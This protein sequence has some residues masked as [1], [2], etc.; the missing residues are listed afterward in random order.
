MERQ[1]LTSD[2]LELR[3]RTAITRTE[4]SRPVAQA[5]QDGVISGIRSVLDYGCGRGDDVVRLRALGH[6]AVGWD[7]VFAPDGPLEPADVVNLGYVINVIE[8]PVERGETL[9]RAWQLAKSALVVAARLD[10]QVQGPACGDGIRTSKG[11]F[12]KFYSQYELKSW[13]EGTL[14]CSAHAAAPGVF[15]VFRDVRDAESFRARQVRRSAAAP[16]AR[17]T[18]V[19]YEQHRD[20]LQELAAFLEERGRLPDP[21]ELAKG[22]SLTAAFGSVRRAFRVLC[23]ESGRD[24]WSAEATRAR[25]NLLVYL[26]L[27]A[28]AGRPRM[29]A[30]PFDVQC[31]VKEFFGSY[32]AAVA[33]ADRLLFSLKSDDELSRAAQGLS[34]GKV[35]PD[36]VYFHISAMPLL[37]PLLRVYEGCGKVLAGT[38]PADVIKLH[39]RSRKI[40]YLFYPAFEKNPHPALEASLR[41]DL[42]T[43]NIRFSDF[44]DSDNPPILHRKDTLISR[45]HPLYQKFSRLTAQEERADL[46][47]IPGIGT[48]S[49]W[50]KLL[51]E[52]GWRLAGH[53]LLRAPQLWAGTGSACARALGNVEAA[54]VRCVP[55]SA[56]TV[57]SAAESLRSCRSFGS[58]N[59]D[60]VHLSRARS[61]I[62]RW[63]PYAICLHTGPLEPF[64]RAVDQTAVQRE[65][66]ARQCNLR[67]GD[68]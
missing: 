20:L 9:H 25:D 15:Y 16:P 29:G 1:N 19:L 63:P 5:I 41:V 3:A 39:R 66:R 56:A 58:D 38:V 36:A 57:P 32:R 43:F 44:R 12:Q 33:E 13:I 31:D 48:R 34:F 52:E 30:L 67:P 61:R 21:S 6:S 14:G 55:G 17:I 35:L 8:A 2:G 37:S 49:A 47:G 23:Q 28:F 40:S 59:Q 7:P 62:D 10:W 22:S 4:L 50:N 65:W 27:S 46:L 45:D 54:K 64:R 26:A 51:K 60:G 68:W 18:R 11:T 42:R 53:R 24:D